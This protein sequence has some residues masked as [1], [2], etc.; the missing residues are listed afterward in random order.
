MLRW[1]RFRAGLLLSSVL[2]VACELNPTPVLP[3][4]DLAPQPETPG[5]GGRAGA[6]TAGTGGVVIIPP[7]DTPTGGTNN[8]GTGAAFTTDPD[9]GADDGGA[10]EANTSDGAGSGYGGGSGEAGTS[11]DVGGEGGT[12]A[13]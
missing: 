5:A 9:A 2:W 3:T 8:E 11:G 12:R 13:L 1:T 10:G 6:G 7:A 4:S